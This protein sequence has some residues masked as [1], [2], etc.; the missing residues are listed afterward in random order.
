MAEQPPASNEEKADLVA[1]LDGELDAKTKSA[2]EARLR[3]DPRARAEVDAMS[4][5]WE[6]LDYLPQPQPSPTFT[7]RTLERITGLRPAARRR[8]AWL[9]GLGWAAGLLLAAGASF[10]GV[11]WLLPRDKT[12]AA[13]ARDLRIL[14]N[15]RLYEPVED[16]DYLWELG[17]PDLFGDEP[18]S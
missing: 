18:G 15:R 8:P 5:V 7:H 4:R 16:I 1:Y 9:L 14:E 12:D 10:A 2:I 3:A 13:L 6:L 11:Y 17:R